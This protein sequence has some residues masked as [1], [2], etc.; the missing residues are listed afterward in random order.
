M[1]HLTCQ[2]C[3]FEL[4]VDATAKGRWLTCP[5]CLTSVALKTTEGGNPTTTPAHGVTDRP[6]RS[7]ESVCPNC[8]SE[9]K[10]SWRLCPS[11]EEPLRERRLRSEQPELELDVR[12]DNTASKV[13]GIVLGSLLVGGVLL[14]FV[15]GAAVFQDL[16]VGGVLV[17]G[18]FL[19]VL[20]LLGSAAIVLSVRNQ[21]TYAIY[22]GLT[23]IIIAFGTALIVVVVI[24][25]AVIAFIND[26]MTTCKCK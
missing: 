4:E 26:V 23:G 8:G 3:K 21:A 17:F 6:A 18:G 14:L 16:S 7:G 19:L 9:V 1:P 13:V 2:N 15:A 25:L 10:P 12:R 11:C 5:R 20:L 22:A 24:V